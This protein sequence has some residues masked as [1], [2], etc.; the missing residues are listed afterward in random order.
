MKFAERYEHFLQ[1]S[2]VWG[3]VVKVSY[4]QEQG[5]GLFLEKLEAQGWLDLLTYTK[6][7]CSVP[8][9]AEFYG[10]CVVTNGVVTSTVN[11]HHLRFDAKK[12]GELLGVS[13]KGF[14]V[15]VWEDNSILGEEWL[16]ELTQKLAKTLSDC[17]PIYEKG[18]NHAIASTIVFVCD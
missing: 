1:K 18:G 4:F 3:K 14:D 16:L 12:L 6:R 8:D 17:V 7:K 2:V 10:N 5:V 9:L 15:Y 11:D 13:S